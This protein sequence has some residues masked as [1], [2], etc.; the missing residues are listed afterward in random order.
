LLQSLDINDTYMCNDE[1]V[2]EAKQG[3][4]I[5]TAY[6]LRCFYILDQYT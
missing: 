4:A 3:D 1:S 2:Q 5:V 6:F